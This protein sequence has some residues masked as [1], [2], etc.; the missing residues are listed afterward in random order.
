[1]HLR[2]LKTVFCTFWL[3]VPLVAVWTF[4][5]S[6]LHSVTDRTALDVLPQS[7]GSL[8][9]Q[10]SLDR[11]CQQRRSD[12]MFYDRMSTASLTIRSAISACFQ[13]FSNSH[14]WS[15]THR[16]P[17]CCCKRPCELLLCTSTRCSWICGTGTAMLIT[18]FGNSYLLNTLGL[19]SQFPSESAELERQHSAQHCVNTRFRTH[20][21][22]A[23]GTVIV[24]S[25]PKFFWWCLQIVNGAQKGES[26]V[27]HFLLHSLTV[28]LRDLLLVIILSHDDLNSPR[29]LWGRTE[30]VGTP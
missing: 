3:S 30:S 27:D 8:P 6:L 21:I 1:M 16:T 26:V 25:E 11:C 28:E 20:L 5:L 29:P 7:S 13:S 18:S 4:W 19:L 14:H 24:S 12:R 17:L 22:L 10:S 9:P 23:R 15:L 2:Q